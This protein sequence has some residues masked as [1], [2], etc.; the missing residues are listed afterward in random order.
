MDR[1]SGHKVV[2]LQFAEGESF[3]NLDRYGELLEVLPPR[4]KLRIERR[5]VPRKLAAILDRHTIED[6]IV[7]DP[8]L[9]EVIAEMFAL[10][11]VKE[12][13]SADEDAMKQVAP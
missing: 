1:F 9:E 6:V 4:A 3:D 8:P 12:D 11:N 10:V 7:E 13:E 5:E 2:T